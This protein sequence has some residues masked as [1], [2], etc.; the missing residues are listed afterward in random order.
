M[1]DRS[2]EPMLS[3]TSLQT[4]QKQTG[5]IVENAP[6]EK[7]ISPTN[8]EES[9]PNSK[10]LEL[11]LRLLPVGVLLTAFGYWAVVGQIPNP[12]R[13]RAVI[14]VPRSSV[15]LQPRERGRILALNIRSGDTVKKG[16][17]VA[18]L[19]FPELETELEDKRGRLA[20]L[21][22]QNQQIKSVEV[23][24]SQ[25]TVNAVEV[26]RQANFRQIEALK[27]QLASN[28]SQRKAYLEHL[29]HPAIVNSKFDSRLGEP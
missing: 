10:N 18:I 12:V 9:S 20:D 17:V 21:K 6:Q 22:A 27:V 5:Q 16:Q 15:H 3:S 14:L 24:R 23:D 13:G 2:S 19:E 1:S 26:Q 11:L 29:H 25:S 28:Q 8:P 4:E 7:S